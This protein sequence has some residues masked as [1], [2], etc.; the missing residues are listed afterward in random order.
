MTILLAYSGKVNGWLACR[1][2]P[3]PPG[4]IAMKSSLCAGLFVTVPLIFFA[5]AHASEQLPRLQVADLRSFF[6]GEPPPP[7]KAPPPKVLATV[8]TDAG[9]AVQPQVEAFFRTLAEAVKARD[10]KP[11]LARLSAKYSVDDLPRDLK[12]GDFFQQ[13]MERIAGPSAIVIKSVEQQGSVRVVGAE[14]RYDTPPAKLK[15]FRFDAEG[16]LLWS[17]LFRLQ[18]Q[19]HGG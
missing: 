11:M 9:V 14:F 12:P 7:P 2:R 5:A 18:T 16:K 1:R 6:H 3:E 17:D 15:S 4:K 8:S 10:G 19:S 13:A